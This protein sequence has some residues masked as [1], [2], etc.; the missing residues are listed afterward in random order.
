MPK[1]W[2]GGENKVDGISFLRREIDRL[3]DEFAHGHWPFSLAGSGNGKLVPTV[4]MSETDKKIEV[5]AEL[6]GVEEKDI[7][8]SL[9][10]DKLTIKA[11]KKSQSKQTDNDYFLLERSYGMFA[12]TMTL[13]CEIAKKKVDAGFKNGVLSIT[14]PKSSKLKVKKK[15]IKV[16]SR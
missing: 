5:T 11:E 10:G 12:R 4:N 13:P 15:K 7:D 1:I 3:F 16:Q 8:V 14:L 2:G 9:A 6:P